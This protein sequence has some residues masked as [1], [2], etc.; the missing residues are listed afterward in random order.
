MGLLDWGRALLWPDRCVLCGG[1]AAYGEICC[2]LCRRDTPL[3]R[4]PVR[5]DGLTVAAVWWYRGLVPDAVGRFKFHGDRQAGEKIARLMAGAWR[6]LCPEFGEDCVTFVPIP[7][8]RERQ[9]GYNQARLLAQWVG[10]EL[11]LPVVPLLRRE[12]VLMQHQLSAGFRR[13]GIRKAFRTLPG[14]EREAA[15]RRILLVDDVVTTGGTVRAC[16][17]QLLDAGAE[18]VAVLAIAIAGEA[19]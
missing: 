19:D 18:E 16:A 8:E 7:P 1:V 2:P 11:E 12:G 9:R 4:Q 5:L 13:K 15:G 3:L 14:A 10:G 17:R 6:E